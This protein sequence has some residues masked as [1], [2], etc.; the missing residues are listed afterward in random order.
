MTDVDDLAWADAALGDDEVIEDIFCLTYVKDV[1]EI[2]VLR[3]MGGLP[4][5]IAVRTHEQVESLADYDNGY[6]DVALV[7][8]MGEWTVVFEPYGFH[9]ASLFDALSRGTEAVCVQRHDYAESMFGYAVDGELITAFD[10]LIPAYRDGADPDRLLERMIEIG[11]NTVDED[12]YMDDP[13]F[14]TIGSCLLLARQLT[15]VLPTPEALTG[16]LTSV[17]LEP[18]FGEGPKEPAGRPG[19][20]GPIDAVAEVRR[21]ATLHGLTGTPGLAEA[22]ASAESGTPVRV[23]PDSPLGRHVRE[24]LI[25]ATRA[26]RSLNDHG[27]QRRMTEADRRRAFDLGWLA[28]ALGAALQPPVSE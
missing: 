20:D 13:E 28:R 7:Q 15:G 27:A 3:R 4:D 26:S 23:T 8:R 2:E 11:F 16:P 5:T 21:L 12:D 9:G 18:W 25:A 14:G 6:P 17:Y 1:D 10:P 22:L 24:W 19:H